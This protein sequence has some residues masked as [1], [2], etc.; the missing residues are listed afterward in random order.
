MAEETLAVK[1]VEHPQVDTLHLRGEVHYPNLSFETMELDFGCILNDTEVIRYVTITNSSPLVVKFRWFFLVDD[2]EN[3]IRGCV[4]GPTF[5]FNV[6]ALHFGD[7]SFGFPHTL[8]CSLNNTSLVPMTFKLRVPGDGIGRKSISNS[9]QYSD[10]KRPPW[11]KD[12][13]P[14]TKP[15]EFTITPDCGT[16]RS[17]GFAAIRV[18]LCSNTV[19]KYELALVVDVEGIGE[20]VLA[21]LITARCVVP[22]LHV[23][24]T[25]MDFGHCFLKYQYEKMIQLVNDDDLPGCYEVLPQVNEASP[26]VLLSSPS[27]C[28]IISPHSTV[29]IPLTLET[30]ITGEHR[31]TVYISIF[32][33]QDPPLECHVRSIGEGPVIYVHPIQVD[34]GTIYVL[35]DSSRILNLSN[36]SFIPALFQ[37]HMAHKKSLWRV[38]PS[39]GVVR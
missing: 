15:K 28:G 37:A 36:Q 24:N 26:A 6:P 10:N 12:E 1:Y 9:E 30:Q 23:V 13:V 39:E 7:V 35:Q 17:Q 22:A 38:E 4:I 32:G 3:Q 33:S 14:V 5:H 21:L 25:K 27:P 16:I 8:I 2:E 18:T 31:S 19:Q 34:F 20:E 29:D 11:S